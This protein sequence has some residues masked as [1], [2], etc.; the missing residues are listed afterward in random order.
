MARKF[1]ST[2]EWLAYIRERAEASRFAGRPVFGPGPEVLSRIRRQ[3][4]TDFLGRARRTMRGGFAGS[5]PNITESERLAQSPARLVSRNRRIADAVVRGLMNTAGVPIP[6]SIAQNILDVANRHKAETRQVAAELRASRAAFEAKRGTGYA[7]LRT[8]RHETIDDAINT[9]VAGRVRGTDFFEDMGLDVPYGPLPSDKVNEIF[10]FYVSQHREFKEEVGGYALPPQ[11]MYGQGVVAEAGRE[12][13][14]FEHAILQK[15]DESATDIAR[16]DRDMRVARRALKDLGS[17]DAFTSDAEYDAYNRAWHTINLLQNDR[18]KIVSRYYEARRQLGYLFGHGDLEVD[19]LNRDLSQVRTLDPNLRA[20]LDL[21]I[22][23]QRQLSTLE[24]EV[25]PRAAQLLRIDTQSRHLARISGDAV[26]DLWQEADR[27]IA[28]LE[29]ESQK[30]KA[31]AGKIRAG[32][33]QGQRTLFELAGLGALP[34]MDEAGEWRVGTGVRIPMGEYRGHELRVMEILNSKALPNMPV[35]ETEI[36]LRL[37]PESIMKLPLGIE[38][39][40]GSIMRNLMSQIRIKETG[41]TLGSI[42]ELRVFKT[43]ATPAEIMRQARKDRD[44]RLYSRDLTSENA[45]EYFERA[46]AAVDKRYSALI[47]NLISGGK[48]LSEDALSTELQIGG[49]AKKIF[50]RLIGEGEALTPARVAQELIAGASVLEPGRRGTPWVT[51]ALGFRVPGETGRLDAIY[52][53]AYRSIFMYDN[54][55]TRSVRQVLGDAVPGQKGAVRARGMWKDFSSRI[56]QVLPIS[57][58]GRTADIKA[59]RGRILRE[60]ASLGNDMPIPTSTLTYLN[61]EGELTMSQALRRAEAR[62]SALNQIR[63]PEDVVDALSE[64]ELEIAK[65]VRGIVAEL[66]DV[67]LRR[68]EA[69]AYMRRAG[70]GQLEYLLH[71]H[72]SLTDR[73]SELERRVQTGRDRISKEAWKLWQRN[74]NS[75]HLAAEA[76]ASR[77][78]NLPN[79]EF[80]ALVE[81]HRLGIERRVS[82]PVVQAVSPRSRSQEFI[83]RAETLYSADPVRAVDLQL[84]RMQEPALRMRMARFSSGDMRIQDVLHQGIYEDL[85]KLHGISDDTAESVISLFKNE[86]IPDPFLGASR[87]AII[88]RLGRLRD[89]QHI[90]QMEIPRF[91]ENLANI[92]GYMG[93]LPGGPSMVISEIRDLQGLAANTQ[94]IAVTFRMMH[95]DQV[96][97]MAAINLPK[98]EAAIRSEGGRWTGMKIESRRMRDRILEMAQ[99]DI[100]SGGLPE[101]TLQYHQKAVSRGLTDGSQKILNR[102]QAQLEEERLEGVL[103]LVEL[104]DRDPTQA[105]QNLSALFGD[106]IQSMA[107]FVPVPTD[108]AL[109][110][111]RPARFVHV[112]RGAVRVAGRNTVTSERHAL[113]NAIAQRSM[114]WQKGLGVTGMRRS[115]MQATLFTDPIYAP[116]VGG[117]RQT[118]WFANIVPEMDEAFAKYGLNMESVQRISEAFGGVRGRVNAID[119]SERGRLPEDVRNQ[120]RELMGMAEGKRFR[121]NYLYAPLAGGHIIPREGRNSTVGEMMSQAA[122]MQRSTDQEIEHMARLQGLLVDSGLTRAQMMDQLGA[123]GIITPKLAAEA[124]AER[125]GPRIHAMYDPRFIQAI[126]NQP[127]YRPIAEALAEQVRGI[128][129]VGFGLP[130]KAMPASAREAARMAEKVTEAPA[131]FYKRMSFRGVA[132]FWRDLSPMTRRGTAVAVGGLATLGALH[133]FRRKQDHTIDDINPPLLPGGSPYEKLPKNYNPGAAGY[134]LPNNSP[135]GVTYY[136]R[137]SG[138]INTRQVSQDLE[139]LVGAPVSGTIYD[140][141]SPYRA[142]EAERMIQENYA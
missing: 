118:D 106:E 38:D 137:I 18:P 79:A 28:R 19:Q 91:R 21:P 139:R 103:S 120:L 37:R 99:R 39:P 134:Q 12:R 88:Q 20:A 58:E 131:S 63:L 110:V 77:V 44:A 69:L 22:A 7:G 93:D 128:I 87:E 73:L 141:P 55:F 61:D 125:V 83:R 86:H 23:T 53:E 70:P 46:T 108:E 35:S 56:R 67:Y 27:T 140:T 122:Y 84:Q 40:E 31:V 71:A 102:I 104:G 14:V 45:M 135:Q 121:E 32:V 8:G 49:E 113:N 29:R 3:G 94:D 80:D 115:E 48:D 64:R 117:V 62:E 52:T 133:S 127:E 16:L 30:I 96:G 66:G 81:A 95:H 36:G 97:A 107:H 136:V 2:A 105:A 33:A 68:G 54:Q 42:P 75:V 1:T 57:P 50:A 6:D 65:E 9:L 112:P 123:Q 43:A 100:E 132:D 78:S 142:G 25:G 47:S 119:L 51:D 85:A 98:Y 11:G 130:S 72:T 114:L 74:K 90:M 116:A 92:T 129:E 26:P 89:D 60:A 126:S 34:Y 111:I 13:S 124:I 15:V 5:L 4:F 82:A 76:H 138:D 41:N 59:E 24:E 10:D 109:D 101:F 17:R